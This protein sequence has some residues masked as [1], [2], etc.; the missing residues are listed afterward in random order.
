VVNEG[1]HPELHKYKV[2]ICFCH[3]VLCFFQVYPPDAP[4]YYTLGVESWEV[5]SACDNEDGVVG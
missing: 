3:R 5:S 1:S 2:N 4:W